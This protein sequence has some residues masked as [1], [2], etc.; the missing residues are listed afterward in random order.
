MVHTFVSVPE[1]IF[2][3]HKRKVLYRILDWQNQAK[4]AKWKGTLNVHIYENDRHKRFFPSKVLMFYNR[5]SIVEQESST[6]LMML[7][8]S[9][10]PIFLHV[11][12]LGVEWNLL[13][14]R[15]E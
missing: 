9:V 10:H 11:F 12:C 14:R 13:A 7:P 3:S 15:S 4:L 8:I 6:V 2:T 1:T 5:T